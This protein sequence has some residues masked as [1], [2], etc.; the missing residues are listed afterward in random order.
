MSGATAELLEKSGLDPLR[1]RDLGFH[2]LRDLGRAE[3]VFQVEADFLPNEFPPLRSLDSPELSHN[4]PSLLSPFVGRERELTQ[5]RQLLGESRLVTLTGSGGSGKT[6]L[7]LHLAAD[8]LD[9]AADGVFIVELAPIADPGQL[10]SAVAAVLGVKQ[11]GHRSLTDSLLEALSDQR[12][13]IL[14]DNC[15]HLVD[16]S[17]TFADLVTRRCPNL[18]LLAT[19]REPLGVDGERVYRVPSLSLPPAGADSVEEL[20]SSDAVRLFAERARSLDAAFTLD[21][22]VAALVVSICRRL[23]GIPLAL[24][25]AAARLSSMSLVH[26]H[27]R[28]DQRFRLL[29]GGSRNALPRQRTLQA[30]VDWSFGLLTAGEQDLLRRLSVFASGFELEAGE[31]VGTSEAVDAFD[32]ADVLGSL[33]D[34]SLVIAERDGDSLRYRLLETIAD[35]AAQ[36]LLSAGGEAA[37]LEA[38]NRHASFYLALAETAAPLLT[39][40]RQGTW[41]R[42]LDLEWD[43]LRA[44]FAHLSASSG[45]A[46]GVMRLGVALLRFFLSRGHSDAISYLREA[47]DDRGGTPT[48]LV[49]RALVTTAVLEEVLVS[50]KSSESIHHVVEITERALEAARAIGDRALEASALALVAGSAYLDHDDEKASLL[51]EEAV[52]IA[53]GLA[54]EQLLGET[55]RILGHMLR[56]SAIVADRQKIHSEALACARRTGDAFSV[57]LELHSLSALSLEVDEPATARRYLEE[58]VVLASDIGAEYLLFGFRSDL[59]SVL[60]ATGDVDGAAALFRTGLVLARRGGFRQQFCGQVFGAACCA[61]WLGDYVRAARLHGAADVAVAA[62]VEARNFGWTRTE[63]RVREAARAEL[64]R[65]LDPEVRQREY[66]IGTGLSAAEV[67]DLALGRTPIG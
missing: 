34:K 64:R 16:A 30:M 4:L 37:V 8:L 17:A 57:A 65:R 20:K 53:R 22:S 62:G 66:D 67:V 32:V 50:R 47:I 11:E 51:A 56:P 28:L 5:V 55:L 40:P 1:L 45:G 61:T 3:Q 27:D 60:L 33:V 42:K 58:A 46:D 48:P 23:D 2:R 63:D 54:D 9:S 38:R 12:V 35:Y 14:L 10:P 21:E 26:L 6:R 19:S 41:L 13:L 25:L 18:R 24:E 29:T 39:G 59:G 49:A 31:A 52:A 44:A 43:N 36:E 7:A 15:E